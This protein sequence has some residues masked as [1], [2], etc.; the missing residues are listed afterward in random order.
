MSD[1]YAEERNTFGI[2]RK[3]TQVTEQGKELH[4]ELTKMLRESLGGQV[5]YLN[6]YVYDLAM[7]KLHE[8]ITDVLV[9]GDDKQVTELRKDLHRFYAERSYRYITS[10]LDIVDEAKP[11]R[12]L[13]GLDQSLRKKRIRAAF[14]AVVGM[15]NSQKLK[16][17]IKG[18]LRAKKW[19]EHDLIDLLNIENI[20]VNSKVVDY[21]EKRIP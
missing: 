17:Q 10:E 12:A 18:K 6:A 3:G 8:H 14:K 21:M 1:Q 5:T 9:A 11:I 7:R 16:W 13:N 2:P 20:N 4:S 19:T 15:L